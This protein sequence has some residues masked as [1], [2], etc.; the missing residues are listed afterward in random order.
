[1]CWYGSVNVVSG[2]AVVPPSR[3]RHPR[4]LIWAWRHNQNSVRAAVFKIEGQSMLLTQALG[5]CPT[6][7]AGQETLP[8][9]WSSQHVADVAAEN[10]WCSE[11]SLCPNFPPIRRSGQ[12]A[13]GND[14]NKMSMIGGRRGGMREH[15]G[16]REGTEVGLHLQSQ[17]ES[18][19]IYNHRTNLNAI[20]E[21]PVLFH[22]QG[23]DDICLCP[24]SFIMLAGFSFCHY[25]GYSAL[26]RPLKKNSSHGSIKSCYSHSDHKQ[27]ITKS[28]TQ[29]DGTYKSELLSCQLSG[30]RLSISPTC[31]VTNLSIRRSWGKAGHR[32]SIYVDNNVQFH[33][34][35]F[36][37]IK[38]MKHI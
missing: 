13:T 37:F 34:I 32:F 36:L 18:R 33:W 3:Q 10:A 19:V 11:G 28:K 17:W 16:K 1:M 20:K 29:I 26:S 30:M 4:M 15:E 35:R 14:C 9:R 27:Y 2:P 7:K 38:L 5:L 22:R 24:T 25:T 31:N 12:I 21:W 8:N 23:N 6:P